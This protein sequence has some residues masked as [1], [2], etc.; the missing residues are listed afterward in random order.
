LGKRLLVVIWDK[1]SWH[2]GKEL[3]RWYGAYNRAAKREGKIRLLLVQLPGRSPWLN[4]LEAIFS[5]TKRRLLG[6]NQVVDNDVLQEQVERYFIERY[7]P[8]L[9]TATTCA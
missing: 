1:A 8:P 2:T 6:R 3:W 9:P 5:Q 4:P 7:L